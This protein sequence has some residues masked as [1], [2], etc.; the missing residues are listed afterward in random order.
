MNIVVLQGRLTRDTELKIVGENTVCN[1]SIAV[2]KRFKKEESIF[3]DCAAWGKTAEFISKYFFKGS[4]ILVQG[5]LDIR[6]YEKDGVKHKAT[7]VIV[8]QVDFAGGKDDK[9]TKEAE[10]GAEQQTV[11]D[12]KTSSDDDD[13]PF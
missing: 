11:E 13:L 9:S 2:P 5:E 1:F 6:N 3:V 8:G 4:K 7:S 12:V 10:V